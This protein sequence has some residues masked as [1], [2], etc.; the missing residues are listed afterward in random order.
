[1]K[2]VMGKGPEIIRVKLRSKIIRD[3]VRIFETKKEERERARS[4]MSE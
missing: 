2:N 3:I 1:M 4:I